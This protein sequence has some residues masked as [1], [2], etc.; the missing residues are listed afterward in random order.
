MGPLTLYQ[1][2]GHDT[3]HF[4]PSSESSI[5]HLAHQTDFSTT[6]DQLDLSLGQKCSQG[7]GIFRKAGI[8]TGL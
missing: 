2:A 4:A 6:K 1:Q 5:S 8:I 3:Y 7:A